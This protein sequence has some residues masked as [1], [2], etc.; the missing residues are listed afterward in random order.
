MTR[1]YWVKPEPGGAFRVL[2]DQ[3]QKPTPY[4]AESFEQLLETAPLRCSTCSPAQFVRLHANAAEMAAAETRATL[5][6]ES[7]EFCRRERVRKGLPATDADIVREPELGGGPRYFPPPG[8][9]R[10]ECGHM[11]AARTGVAVQCPGCER[12]HAPCG[13]VDCCEPP[14]LAGG[15]CEAHMRVGPGAPFLSRHAADCNLRF[16]ALVWRGCSCAER[17]ERRRTRRA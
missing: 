16:D 13:V 6:R 7:I 11:Y 5:E 15:F 8:G 10:C 1:N 17:F 4:V 3:C 12:M 14:A 2:C 9:K